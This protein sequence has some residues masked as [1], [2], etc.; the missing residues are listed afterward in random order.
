MLVWVLIF[1]VVQ[2]PVVIENIK[3]QADCEAAANVIY[4]D[5]TKYSRN[6]PPHLCFSVV[7]GAGTVTR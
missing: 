6:R 2:G 4:A 3:T 5:L 7:K 1:Y